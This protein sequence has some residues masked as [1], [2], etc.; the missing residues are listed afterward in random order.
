[1]F[2]TFFFIDGYADGMNTYAGHFAAG[3]GN[4]PL[5][6]KDYKIGT[7]D[8]TMTPDAGSGAWNQTPWT[9]KLWSLKKLIQGNIGIVWMGMPDA[10][11]HIQHYLGNT[12][13]DY[14]ID[15]DDM[16]DDVPSVKTHTD[17]ETA[18]A[19]A[20][21][22]TLANG[23]HDVT[24]GSGSTG[25]ATKAQSW[26]W[27][28]AV[29]G[30]SAWGKGKADVCHGRKGPDFILELELKF[31]DRYNWDGGKSVTILGVTV[32]DAFMQKF[33]RQGLAKEF[34]MNGV[35]VQISSVRIPKD[36]II[37]I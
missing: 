19:Q 13:K 18:L 25:Y 27:F 36:F 28:Y 4:D 30:Y 21:V 29:G 5:G 11:N 9:W 26:N 32:T 8:P 16:I 37:R 2:L 20:F 12:G 1:M 31:Y 3:F 17:T 33:H 34:D 22:E 35:G 6:L 10:V 24:S 7:A 14:T 23:K 15:F